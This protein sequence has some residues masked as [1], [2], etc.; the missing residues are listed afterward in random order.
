VLWE[1]FHERSELTVRV[2]RAATVET[3]DEI[4]YDALPYYNFRIERSKLWVES[5]LEPEGGISMMQVVCSRLVAVLDGNDGESR[6]WRLEIVAADDATLNAKFPSVNWRIANSISCRKVPIPIAG[7]K[8]GIWDDARLDNGW[9]S[10]PLMRADPSTEYYS[11]H[12]YVEWTSDKNGTLTSPQIIE[13]GNN[14]PKNDRRERE[15]LL[16]GVVRR[17][18]NQ[19]NSLNVE[20]IFDGCRGIYEGDLF[21]RILPEAL[22]NLRHLEV[23]AFAHHDNFHAAL[24]AWPS[25]R[26]ISFGCCID[27][28]WTSDGVFDNMNNHT[29]L[30]FCKLPYESTFE[31]GESDIRTF[32]PISKPLTL[33][34]SWIARINWTRFAASVA[35]QAKT[36]RIKS[37]R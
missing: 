31:S 22:P 13:F 17:C 25:L 30:R 9:R 10:E 3:A 8:W 11:L 4:V 37:K 16:L 26:S 18:G 2:W 19:V 6:E 24:R 34:M 29:G 21:S 20:G 27:E 5:L 32:V 15:A 1:I 33:A 35:A 12:K 23:A 14:L 36:P 28:A 7:N